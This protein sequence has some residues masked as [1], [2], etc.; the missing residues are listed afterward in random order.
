MIF[1]DPTYSPRPILPAFPAIK[2]V[3]PD[4]PFPLDREIVRYL[5]NQPEAVPTWTM[6]KSNCS[7]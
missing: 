3:Q 7:N 4:P 1:V 6:I 5:R 2:P